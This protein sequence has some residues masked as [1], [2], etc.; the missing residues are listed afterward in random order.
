MPIKMYLALTLC[1]LNLNGCSKPREQNKTTG[2][3]K[4]VRVFS[5]SEMVTEKDR[6]VLRKLWL[7]DAKAVAQKSA[8]PQALQ[9]SRFLQENNV[10]A[11][12]APMGMRFIEGSE[13]NPR[14]FAIVMLVVG[15]EHLSP[16][17]ERF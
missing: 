14:W 5:E 3:K 7:E 17:I 2:G 16:L 12:P 8:D 11:E 4:E 1:V 10:L 9:V 15:D 13:N 6:V